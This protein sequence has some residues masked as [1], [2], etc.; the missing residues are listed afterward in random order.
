MFRNVSIVEQCGRNRCR[1]GRDLIRLTRIILQSKAH[2]ITQPVQQQLHYSSPHGIKQTLRC[3]RFQLRALVERYAQMH[4]M[5]TEEEAKRHSIWC[6][7]FS[8]KATKSAQTWEQTHYTLRHI[9]RAEEKST[10]RTIDVIISDY[11]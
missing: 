1:T 10:A 7:C 2:Q 8:I 5:I 11:F 9:M 3:T 4:H 6:C